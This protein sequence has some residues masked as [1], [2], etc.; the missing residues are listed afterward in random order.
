[1]GSQKVSTSV[2]SLALLPSQ[3]SGEAAQRAAI[4]TD[5]ICYAMG[6]WAL[7]SSLG[8]NCT[9]TCSSTALTMGTCSPAGT[10]RN[11]TLVLL[12]IRSNTAAG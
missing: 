9:S 5:P 3:A 2:T 4:S 1:M 6:T 10:D 8:F 11:R 7:K 12:V